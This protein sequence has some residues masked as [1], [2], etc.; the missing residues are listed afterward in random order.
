MNE[1]NIKVALIVL[2]GI[3]WRV[4]T[5]AT[6]SEGI[7]VALGA[8]MLERLSVQAANRIV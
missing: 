2:M 5:A 7:S 3:E 8:T 6:C 1:S 4:A